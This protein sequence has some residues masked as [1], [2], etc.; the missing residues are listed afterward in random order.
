MRWAEN[1]AHTAEREREREKRTGYEIMK[2]TV[3][4][5][6]YGP[7]NYRTAIS[8]RTPTLQTVI[9]R[10]IVCYSDV[11]SYILLSVNLNLKI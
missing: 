5:L 7:R 9:C 1:V 6:K 11:L 4:I 10:Y 2:N 3:A 8:N